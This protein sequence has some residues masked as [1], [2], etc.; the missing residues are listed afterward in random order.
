MLVFC[1][2]PLAEPRAA[3]VTRTHPWSVTRRGGE[4]EAR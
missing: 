2:Y 1:A 3:E 4:R